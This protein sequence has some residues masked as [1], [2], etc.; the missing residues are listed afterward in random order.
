MSERIRDVNNGDLI[1]T[2]E[3]GRPGT[4]FAHHQCAIREQSLDRYNWFAND[5]SMGTVTSG[6]CEFCGKP[7]RTIHHKDPLDN[8]F[9]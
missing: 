1:V 3:N 5:K 2:D 8:H 9:I 6:T 7:F 4:I